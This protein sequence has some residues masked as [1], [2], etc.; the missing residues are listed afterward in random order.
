MV[1]VVQHDTQQKKERFAFH[2]A[3]GR[4]DCGQSANLKHRR[5]QA[6]Q[7]HV[8]MFTAPL[9]HAVPVLLGYTLACYARKR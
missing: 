9:F 2:G 6:S 7:K 3:L 1:T 4:T 5:A 8:N